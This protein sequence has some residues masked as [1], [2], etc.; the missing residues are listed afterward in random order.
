[1]SSQKS[2][3]II[4]ITGTSSGFG[5]LSAARLS[6]AGHIVY[7]TMRDINKSTEL[8]NEIAK[9][10]GHIEIRPL[11]V[12][13]IDTIKKVVEEINQTHGCL[14]VVINNAGYG[15]GGFFEDLTQQEIR[16]V[17]DVNF[18]GVQNVCRE[19][20]PVMRKN[21]SGKI[22]NISSIAGLTAAPCFGA[23]NVSKWAIEAFSESLFHEMALFGIKVVLIEP[24][25]YPTKIFAD[26]A[27][28]AK[29]FNNP[30]SPY[31]KVSQQLN[32]WV[33]AQKKKMTRDPEDVAKLIE[34]VINMKNPRLRYISDVRSWLEVKARQFMPKWV[35]GNLLRRINYGN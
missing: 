14:D 23:Y 22:I 26:N 13:Q 32:T 29:D 5:L 11:D 2:Q 8:R 24:G 17:M 18:F 25:S 19:V 4:L 20:I 16:H 21:Q 6:A 28:Y 30:Q 10:G 33:Q 7:A 27:R 15:L 34:K 9:R 3:K 35:Y 31:Y 1:M 12:T